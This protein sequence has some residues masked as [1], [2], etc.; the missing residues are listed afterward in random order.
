MRYLFYLSLLY[1]SDTTSEDAGL[2]VTRASLLQQSRRFSIDYAPQLQRAGG[3]LTELLISSDVGRYLEF[4][5]VA[6]LNLADSDAQPSLFKV[7]FCYTR[8]LM[9]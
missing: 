8:K 1:C 3:A 2:H 9:K 5:H 4:K 7:M 6:A